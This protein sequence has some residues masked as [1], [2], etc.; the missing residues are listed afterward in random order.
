MDRLTDR[1][2][3]AQITRIRFRLSP[4]RSLIVENESSSA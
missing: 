1:S 3:R 4:S 2:P